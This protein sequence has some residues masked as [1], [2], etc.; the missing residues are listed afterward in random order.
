MLYVYADCAGLPYRVGRCAITLPDPIPPYVQ[1]VRH[2]DKAPALHWG[3]I[4]E[5]PISERIALGLFRI[6]S[7]IHKRDDGSIRSV[8]PIVR[9]ARG[10]GP[11]MLPG[12]E[13][14]PPNAE[15]YRGEVGMAYRSFQRRCKD[16]AFGDKPDYGHHDHYRVQPREE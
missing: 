12:F 16:D 8:E 4:R 13:P 7:V 11:E 6:G 3:E 15:D 9:L 10:Q 5:M 1:M 2:G 14:L